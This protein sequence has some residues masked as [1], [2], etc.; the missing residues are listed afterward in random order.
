MNFEENT[1]HKNASRPFGYYVINKD[2]SVISEFSDGP[3]GQDTV[4]TNFK[5]VIKENVNELGLLGLGRRIWISTSDGRIHIHNTNT[6]QIDIELYFDYDSS[7]D[8][9]LI[10]GN[11]IASYEDIIQFKHMYNDL[12]ISDRQ[13]NGCVTDQFCIGYKYT[14]S[15]N[16]GELSLRLL[17]KLD[18]TKPS[19]I[20][21]RLS[22]KFDING[23]FFT[24]VNDNM[25]VPT[26]LIIPN[27]ASET[28]VKTISL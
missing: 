23:Y 20:E 13:F 8:P 7:H 21:V 4:E 19:E 11:K 2:D 27:G 14:I 26:K 9:I 15:T 12:S 5:N 6:P 3:D 1:I 18:I 22:P 28:V 24:K 17:F 25:L 16:A 10:S